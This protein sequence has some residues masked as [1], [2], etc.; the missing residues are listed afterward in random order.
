[1]IQERQRDMQQE[2]NFDQV[3]KGLRS[4]DIE[5]RRQAAKKL[6]AFVDHR[7]V[8]VLLQ[9]FL[10]SSN[11][12]IRGDISNALVQLSKLSVP[13]L[14][15]LL[16]KDD[17]DIHVWAVWTLGKIADQESYEPLLQD[18]LLTRSL[19]VRKTTLSALASINFLRS[20]DVIRG[21]LNNR[22]ASLRAVAVG[23]LSQDKNEKTINALILSSHDKDRN[24]RLQSVYALETIGDPSTFNNIL[25]LLQD[26]DS[27]VRIAAAHALFLLDS[28]QS[29]EPLV[30]MLNDV[31]VSVVF[32]ILVLLSEVRDSHLKEA[33]TALLHNDHAEIRQQAARNLM[34]MDDK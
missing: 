18:F 5:T 7:S 20:I 15:S 27:N 12:A 33:L 3:A 13:A 29:V 25:V 26:S 10:S 8:S 16:S 17:E 6:S 31:E 1:M 21:S 22:N 24:V 9:A 14:I 2:P 28:A 4:D 11:S 30:R 34:L 23:L 19:R 32:N